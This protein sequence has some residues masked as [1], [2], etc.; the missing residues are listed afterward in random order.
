MDAHPTRA[1]Y[2]AQYKAATEALR[3]GGF[4]LRD[5]VPTLLNTANQMTSLPAQGS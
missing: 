1:A 3:R 2:L 4:I 5:D